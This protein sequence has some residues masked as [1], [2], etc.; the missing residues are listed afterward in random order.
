[1]FEYNFCFLIGKY[2][3]NNIKFNN[4][5]KTISPEVNWPPAR[6]LSREKYFLRESLLLC[7]LHAS[8]ILELKQALI[9]III[10]VKFTFIIL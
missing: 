8:M 6:Q 4:V 5:K 1:M 2:T 3:Y 7:Y 9:I 10:N